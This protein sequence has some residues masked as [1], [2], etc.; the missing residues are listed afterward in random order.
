MG[1]STPKVYEERSGDP[2]MDNLGRN[3][4]RRLGHTLRGY[5]TVNTPRGRRR[6]KVIKR[7]ETATY[8]RLVAEFAESIHE[9]AGRDAT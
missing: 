6:K 2:A 4:N 5:L 7:I 8:F 1:F 9:R 3:L